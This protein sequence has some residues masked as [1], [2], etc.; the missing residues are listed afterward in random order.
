MPTESEFDPARF[1]S[2]VAALLSAPR[3]PDLGRGTPVAAALPVLEAWDGPDACR[4]G[5]LLHFD[6]WDAAHAIAQDL[7]TP[8]G[9]YLHA[10]LHRR[11][12]DAFNAGY[13]FRRVGRHPVAVAM[14]A[15]PGYGTPAG[16][17][18]VCE[19]V[20]GT[21]TP[22]EDRAKALQLLEW[23]RLMTHCADGA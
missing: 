23:R 5:L 4:A 22:A 13:W 12:P 19:R 7:D 8:D 16:F 3:V 17:V 21:G 20:R 9:A 15:E 1:G 6:H 2:A 11:E 18:D 14:T 10:I